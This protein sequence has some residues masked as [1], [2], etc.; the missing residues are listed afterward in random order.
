MKKITSL[1][2][3]VKLLFSTARKVLNHMLCKVLVILLMLIAFFCAANVLLLISGALLNFQ[4]SARLPDST[5]W[6]KLGFESDKLFVLSPNY[7][8]EVSGNE[9]KSLINYSLDDFYTK[10]LEYQ[11]SFS[12]LPTKNIVVKNNAVYFLQEILQ[13]R[14]S[15]LLKLNMVNGYIEDY[16]ISL[17]YRDNY[18]KD[19]IDF[20][21]LNDNSLLVSANRLMHN[22]MLINTKDT[23]VNV[24]TFNKMV[25]TFKGTKI[26]LPI[27]TA[28]NVGDTL[29][30]ASGKGL[31][32]KHSD[33]I[34][35]LVYFDNYDQRIKE[36]TGVLVFNFEP[37]SIK[38]LAENI[39]IIGG[40]W[41]GLYQ[42]D[43]LNSTMTCVDDINHDN[44]RTVDLSAL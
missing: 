28:L 9:W 5:K 25:T 34:K 10:T 32:L 24:W 29:V 41:G 21:F 38:K 12:M 39:Y 22:P 4:P 18:S 6:I 23:K 35:P 3:D 1:S 36:K 16:F 37:R 20:T 42:V 15:N 2:S 30:L 40:M 14:T 19:I 44:L 13:G 33:I 7:L 27:T 8:Y 17:D 43:I 31:Y 26:E 11:T